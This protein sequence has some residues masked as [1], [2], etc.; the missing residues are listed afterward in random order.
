METVV[1]VMEREEGAGEVDGERDMEM[2][3]VMKGRE[4]RGLTTSL[5]PADRKE[6]T[7]LK[8]QDPMLTCMNNSCITCMQ[9]TDTCMHTHTHT[10]TETSSI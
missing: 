7:M 10:H 5:A 4:E 1:A 6:R 9:Y 2:T 8:L 3:L